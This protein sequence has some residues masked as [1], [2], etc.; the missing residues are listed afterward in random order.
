M[1]SINELKIP[2]LSLYILFTGI[3]SVITSMMLKRGMKPIVSHLKRL[4]NL[5]LV[6]VSSIRLPLL[7]LLLK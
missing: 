3:N 7:F 2:S 1:K 5:G 6:Q 4:G